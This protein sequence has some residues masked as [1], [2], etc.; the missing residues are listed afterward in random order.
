MGKNIE[1]FPEDI[2]VGQIRADLEAYFSDLKLDGFIKQPSNTDQ[3]FQNFEKFCGDLISAHEQFGALILEVKVR[4]KNGEN[5]FLDAYKEPQHVGLGALKNAGV[6]VYFSYNDCSRTEFKGKSEFLFN[7]GKIR[8]PAPNEL[9]IATISTGKIKS[10]EGGTLLEILQKKENGNWIH[11]CA[12]L[13]LVFNPKESY[14]NS[15]IND[16]NTKILVLIYSDSLGMLIADEAQAKA[17]IEIIK[18]RTITSPSKD[19]KEF[20]DALQKVTVDIESEIKKLQDVPASETQ[21]I[22]IRPKMI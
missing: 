2:L 8:A 21:E 20:L 17:L 13:S 5:N 16:L 6:P 18:S 11:A 1:Y 12:A 10:I 3:G 4:R 15:G 19:G 7:L 14:T 9:L 22:G